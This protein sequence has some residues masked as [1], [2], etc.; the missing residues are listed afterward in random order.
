MSRVEEIEDRVRH[1]SGP[2]LRELR[3]W[4]DDFEAEIWDK[5][6]DADSRAGKFDAL[7]ERA[8][9]DERDGKTTDL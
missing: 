3:A 2:E 6:I 5:Q 8:L 1:L 9:A 7:I 4:L